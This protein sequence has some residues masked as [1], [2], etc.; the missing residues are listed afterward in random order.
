MQIL[1]WNSIDCAT[2]NRLR[3]DVNFDIDVAFLFIDD[4]NLASLRT[5]FNCDV[6]SSKG[7]EYTAASFRSIQYTHLII[8]SIYQLTKLAQL[9]FKLMMND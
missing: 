3:S 5:K 6:K 9:C 8:V 7:F 1:K 2:V 4:E